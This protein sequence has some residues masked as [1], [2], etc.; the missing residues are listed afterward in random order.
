MERIIDFACKIWGVQRED[1]MG[2]SRVQPLT[3]V[4]A[5]IAHTMRDSFGLSLMH[6]GKHLNRNH[7]SI[8]HY[9]K[10]YDAEYKYN[11]QFRTFANAMKDSILEVKS[12]FQEELE[13]EYKE[14]TQ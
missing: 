6:I 1:V 7:T 5:M 8:V 10:L 4:R 14:I 11:K 2:R 3:F 13:E 12:E 9:L